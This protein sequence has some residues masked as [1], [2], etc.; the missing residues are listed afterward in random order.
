MP[1]RV[2]NK[3]ADKLK[4][5]LK[6]INKRRNIREKKY[7]SWRE[8]MVTQRTKRAKDREAAERV[9]DEVRHA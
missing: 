9:L 8:R 1:L 5:E 4:Q 3:E 2:Q 7:T 6:E